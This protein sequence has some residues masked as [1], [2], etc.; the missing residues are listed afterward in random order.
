LGE[1][2]KKKKIERKSPL[3]RRKAQTGKKEGKNLGVFR[4]FVVL[5]KGVAEVGG[6]LWGKGSPGDTEHKI[7]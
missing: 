7:W 5:E 3:E 6:V 2:P 1:R 4:N